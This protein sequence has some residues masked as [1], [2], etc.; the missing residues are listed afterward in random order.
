MPYWLIISRGMFELENGANEDGRCA[1]V[2]TRCIVASHR[3]IGV[4]KCEQLTKRMHVHMHMH[5][6]VAPLAALWWSHVSSF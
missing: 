3:D 6:S 5:A 1:R 2:A 4:N